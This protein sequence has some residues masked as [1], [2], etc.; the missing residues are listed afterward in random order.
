MIVPL[1]NAQ[2]DVGGAEKSAKRGKVI[3]A[4]TRHW[5]ENKG[6]CSAFVKA[7]AHD[8]GLDVTGQANDIYDQIAKSPWIRIG[9]GESAATVAG[10]T[11][12]EGNLVI[13]ATKFQPNG[14][15]AIVV[16]YSNA[17][18]SYKPVEREKAVAFW[19]SLRSV[20]QEYTRITRSWAAAN[21]KDV[22]YAYRPI[23]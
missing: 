5:Q 23:P 6:D 20:G 3:A 11:A 7:V 21:L 18:E 2:A 1:N 15:V 12:G 14:H 10:V 19:G 22:L 9:I 8:L 16:D 4:C 13:A 17:F